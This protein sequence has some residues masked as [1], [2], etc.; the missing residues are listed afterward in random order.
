MLDGVAEAVG[1][2]PHGQLADEEVREDCLLDLVFQAV[3]EVGHLDDVISLVRP[4]KV[5]VPAQLVNPALDVL[6]PVDRARLDS[7]A[8]RER[9]TTREA[10]FVIPL[11]P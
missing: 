11:P 2:V 5:N 10:R 9:C 8:T 4:E 7:V 6:K 3:Y 1:D